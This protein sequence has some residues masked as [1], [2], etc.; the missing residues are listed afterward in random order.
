MS[1]FYS[2]TL[3]E[4]ASIGMGQSPDSETCSE[5]A[6]HT[7]F[8]QGCAEFTDV[9]PLTGIFCSKPTKIA[10]KNS[11]LMSVRAPV[12][13]S[14]IADQVYCIGRGLAYVKSSVIPVEYMREL[15]QV[16]S[17]FLNQR[18]QGLYL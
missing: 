13:K 15:I 17:S 11:L 7:P 6:Q 9:F 18:S 1:K 4:I 8:L 16:N 10:P 2:V 5:N 3:G 12:G 14:N